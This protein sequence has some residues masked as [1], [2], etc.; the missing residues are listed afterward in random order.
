MSRDL[1]HVGDDGSAR[2]VDVSAKPVTQREARAG[3]TVWLGAEVCSLIAEKGG[4]GKGP[5][6]ETA[7]LAGIQA[8]KRTGELI[9]LCHPLSL[10]HI[11]VALELTTSTV[12]IET[13]ARCTSRT[14]VEM[15][16][17]TA[18]AVAA[19]T[20]YDMVKAVGRDAEIRSVRLLEKRGGK[21]GHWRRQQ[22]ESSMP[23]RRSG[24][25]SHE[26]AGS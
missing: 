26:N 11:D 6:L 17:M 4:V 5:V 10:D 15:E 14:G 18:A 8:A 22:E 23:A 1:S 3:A 13:T 7:R 9:P 16:A 20:V 12:L 19:L 25:T 24:T 21:S 2:M